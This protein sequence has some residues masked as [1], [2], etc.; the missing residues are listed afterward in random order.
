MSNEKKEPPKSGKELWTRYNAGERDFCGVDLFDEDLRFKLKKA[1]FHDAYIRWSNFRDAI[2]D[3]A[4]FIRTDLEGSDFRGTHLENT[5]LD[6]AI[7]TRAAF[8]QNSDLMSAKWQTLH[9]GDKTYHRDAVERGDERLPLGMGDPLRFVFQSSR[10]LSGEDYEA[11]RDLITAFGS[12]SKTTDLLLELAASGERFTVTS[13]VDFTEAANVGL[14]VLRGV[15]NRT[16]LPSLQS[17]S[18]DNLL[19]AINDQ[20]KQA[21]QILEMVFRNQ[22]RLDRIQRF[23]ESLEPALIE[24]PNEKV[25]KDFEKAANDANIP[26]D[27]AEFD[28]SIVRFTR[29]LISTPEAW[30]VLAGLIAEYK[31]IPGGFSLG[32]GSSMAAHAALTRKKE[33][34]D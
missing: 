28:G 34:L 33:P 7:L 15:L 21:D 9:F 31:G 6:E 20:T 13:R 23:L 8:D 18:E 2:L 16:E 11:A 30:F 24:F 1:K 5:E 14:A 17:E 32:Y 3:E 10:P 25:A 4:E 22:Q 26:L 19:A 27:D 29:R 12:V